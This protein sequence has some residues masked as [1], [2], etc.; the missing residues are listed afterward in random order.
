MNIIITTVE[1][2]LDAKNNVHASAPP[3]ERSDREQSDI[4][5]MPGK[6][7]FRKLPADVFSYPTVFFN[8]DQN[9]LL[10][11]YRICIVNMLSLYE[12]WE[13]VTMLMPVNWHRNFITIIDGRAEEVMSWEQPLVVYFICKN[14]YIMVGVGWCLLPGRCLRIDKPPIR[15]FSGFTRQTL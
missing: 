15:D 14:I 11:K 10:D 1:L 4:W 13:K 9:F 2:T 3:C 5:R 12:N 8:Y 6:W 7:W